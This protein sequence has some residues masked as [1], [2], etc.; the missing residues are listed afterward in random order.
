MCG[1][2]D[3]ISRQPIVPD[4]FIQLVEA[5]KHRGNLAFGYLQ[6][7]ITDEGVE[8]GVSHRPKPFTSDLVHITHL[9]ARPVQACTLDTFAPTGS[10][11]SCVGDY[12]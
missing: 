2:F 10:R 7:R 6:C 5:N 3:I 1:I 4:D 8:T 12:H 11:S 9:L